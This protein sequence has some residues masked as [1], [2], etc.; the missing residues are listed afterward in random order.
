M[1]VFLLFYFNGL[2]DAIKYKPWKSKEIRQFPSLTTRRLFCGYTCL[3][4]MVSNKFFVAN[5]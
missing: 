3:A 2:I 1:P 5:L 4:K